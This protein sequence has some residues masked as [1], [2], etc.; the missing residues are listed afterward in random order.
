MAGVLKINAVVE[1]SVSFII[2]PIV[3]FD[4]GNAAAFY[5]Y[6]YLISVIFGSGMSSYYALLLIMTMPVTT[7]IQIS[8]KLAFVF[9]LFCKINLRL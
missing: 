5:K 8:K 9:P 6:Y 3:K 4:H 7:E 1:M 2:R